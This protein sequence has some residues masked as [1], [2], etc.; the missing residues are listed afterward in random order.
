MKKQQ[1]D[2]IIIGSGQAGTPLAFKFA[3][4][5][6]NVAFIEKDKFGGTCVN[7]GCTPTKAYVASAKRIND[8]KT[9]SELGIEISETVPVDLE[10]IKERKDKLVN[11]SVEGIKRGVEENEK[12]TFF[13]GEAKFI[14]YKTVEVNKETL[15]A[16]KIFINVGGRPHVPE[17]FEKNDYLT[18]ESILELKEIP[19]HL[20]IAGGSYLGLEF[21]QM[22]RR[23]GSKVS[24]IE[25]NSRIIHWEDKKVSEE[26]QEIMEDEGVSFYLN[27]ECVSSEK[28]REEE[29]TLHFKQNGEKKQVKGSHL[30]LA[31]GRIPNSDLLQVDNSNIKTDDKNFIGV[32]DF[33]ETSVEG[34]YALGDCNGQGAFTHT[35]YNDYEILVNNLFG[36]KSRKV[37]DR[38]KTYGLFID[39]PLGR[40]GLTAHEAEESGYDFKVVEYPMSKVAR[41]KERGNI[42]GFMQAIID[43]DTNKILGA[44]VLG[45]GGDEIINGFTNI[46]YAD[47]AYTVIR[48][49]VF[50]HPTVS[51]LIPTMLEKV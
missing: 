22:F 31:L 37:S 26:I 34:I 44:C 18:N 43:N 42:K 39:P 4:E 25:K 10:K 20:I 30:L 23:F 41:A 36:D 27:A 15:S 33:L 13:H 45:I 46:M 21:G 19:D 8:I 47:V 38:I 49:G 16:E 35:S 5:G 17:A 12:I 48:D 32:N 40:V 50:P 6:K 29:I 11:E 24:I 9:A 51:E 3:E 2:A 14:G 1:F 28:N 7:N